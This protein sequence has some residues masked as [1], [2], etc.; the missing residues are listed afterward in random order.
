[1]ESMLIAS[2]PSSLSSCTR[3]GRVGKWS[4]ANRIDP[5]RSFRNSDSSGQRSV[6]TTSARKASSLEARCTSGDRSV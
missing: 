2:T 4:I 3:L 1:M 5:G 6:R